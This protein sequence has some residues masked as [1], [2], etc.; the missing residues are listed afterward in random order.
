MPIED[1]NCVAD[2]VRVHAK[3]RADVD[4]VVTG[5]HHLTFGELDKRT[6]RVANAMRAAGVGF[7]DR[8]AFIDKNGPNSSR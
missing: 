6:N 3:E 4:A 7:G 8:V 2:I 5:E 1:I